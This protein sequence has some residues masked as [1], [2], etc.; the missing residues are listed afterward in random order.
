MIVEEKRITGI[1]GSILHKYFRL[2][3]PNRCKFI[4]VQ[5]F[6]TRLK[7][8]SYTGAIKLFKERKIDSFG[9]FDL[10]TILNIFGFEL[11]V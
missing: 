7:N 5:E 11:I 1:I 8:L 6:G 10:R 4:S 3:Y 9:E 2:D